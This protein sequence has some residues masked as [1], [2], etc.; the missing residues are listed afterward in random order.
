MRPSHRQPPGS[1]GNFI[2]SRSKPMTSPRCIT[3][4]WRITSCGR[5]HTSPPKHS[6]TAGDWDRKVPVSHRCS[7]LMRGLWKR[8]GGDSGASPGH[9]P[10]ATFGWTL[11][12]LVGV[13]GCWHRNLLTPITAPAPVD[14]PSPR[15]VWETCDNKHPRPI[16]HLWFYCKFNRWQVT[17]CT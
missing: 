5:T 17:E 9:A 6:P 12:T 10:G 3:T 13:S 14:S 11:P 16:I 4:L 15:W 2:V 1:G 8:P 7:A